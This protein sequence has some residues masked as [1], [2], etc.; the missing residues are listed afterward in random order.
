[1]TEFQTVVLILVGAGKKEAN[2]R[3]ENALYFGYGPQYHD[4]LM[5]EA[6]SSRG[7]K[8]LFSEQRLNRYREELQNF[9]DNDQLTR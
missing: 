8:R 6:L 9:P 7:Y 5:E 4:R 2:K 1:M 3:L